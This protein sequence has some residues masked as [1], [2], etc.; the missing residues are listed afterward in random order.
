MT[1]L[2]WV[3]AA[4]CAATLSLVACQTSRSVDRSQLAGIALADRTYAVEAA[5]WGISPR[6]TLLVG[7]YHARTPTAVPGARTVA[8]ADLLR[9]LTTDPSVVL[10]D[11][12]GVAAHPGLPQSVWL[13]DAG[14][15]KGFDEPLQVKLGGRLA[16]LTAGDRQ[17]SIVF[18][19]LLAECWLS[20][21]A[22]LRA[23]AL[24]YRSVLWCRGGIGA[25][26]AA[27]LPMTPAIGSW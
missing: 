16:Q 25:W 13:V 6:G 15:G 5:D 12:L 20:Y 11:V 26:R 7:R 23:V 3:T 27:G 22:S 10:V 18:Y 24:G 17:R 1:G 2:T 4:L 19:C 8:T 14:L 21:N 9:L